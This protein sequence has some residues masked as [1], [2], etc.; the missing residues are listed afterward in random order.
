MTMDEEKHKTLFDMIRDDVMVKLA[1]S[2]AAR[3][4]WI[5]W[6]YHNDPM[7]AGAVDL[8]KCYQL[9]DDEVWKLVICGWSRNKY[10]I[11]HKTIVL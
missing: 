9:S 8:G 5:D 4:Q 10:H 7:V 11:D 3:K 2:A 1:T 6:L